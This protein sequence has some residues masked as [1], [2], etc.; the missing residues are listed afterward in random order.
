V[1]VE[2]P[3]VDPLETVVHERSQLGNDRGCACHRGVDM[4]PQV[5]ASAHVGQRVDGVD[6][7]RRGRAD[8]ADDDERHEVVGDVAVDGGCE[9]VGPH[10][11]GAVDIDEPELVVAQP[12]DSDRLL[13]GRVGLCRRVGTKPLAARGRRLLVTR[14]EDRAQVGARCGVLDHAATWSVAAKPCG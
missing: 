5:T 10:G 12:R 11:E 14:G 1:W 6:G 7:E 4:Q 9:R 3:A 8:G 13:D 2:T